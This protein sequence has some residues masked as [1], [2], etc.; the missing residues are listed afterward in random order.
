[1]ITEL[2][3]EIKDPLILSFE[4]NKN[5]NF[6]KSIID[7]INN[8]NI[9][10]ISITNLIP[11]KYLKKIN[12]KFISIDI[13][14]FEF[15]SSVF[16]KISEYNGYIWQ[17]RLN[18]EWPFI[19]DD[20][21][22]TVNEIKQ[23]FKGSIIV[24]YKNNISSIDL[25]NIYKLIKNIISNK[26]IF[27]FF[28]VLDINENDIKYKNLI[29]LL[30]INKSNILNWKILLDNPRIYKRIT[31]NDVICPNNFWMHIDYHWNIKVCKYSNVIIW[32]INKDNLSDLY[33]KKQNYQK[34]LKFKDCFIYNENITYPYQILSKYYDKMMWNKDE[35][36]KKY[37]NI[38][39]ELLINK[40]SKILDLWAWTGNF[41]YFL[42]K[43]WYLNIHWIEKSDNM[44]NIANLKLWKKIVLNWDFSR[45]FK[46]I[47]NVDIITSTFDSLNY[48]TDIQLLKKT[49]IN[50][51]K[52]LKNN[53]YFIF[54]I[55]IDK[56]FKNHFNLT[57]E[58]IQEENKIYFLS[59]YKKPFW[60]IKIDFLNS[61]NNNIFSESHFEI[62]KSKTFILNLLKEVNF[63]I[64]KYE[65]NKWRLLIVCKKR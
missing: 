30:E 26:Y 9:Q 28:P 23:Y 11:V 37:L 53:W 14:Y 61:K 33:D 39:N 6:I 58:Y 15:K 1:M 62:L 41:L 38:L 47:N 5:I 45:N 48:I 59:S 64:I 21:L 25:Q 40:M 44:L 19:V 54:D 55:N 20:I 52:N 17:I 43:N 36:Y 56:K 63:S 2:S 51:Y 16:K 60:K 8:K 22:K 18:I 12:S 31:W 29:K 7:Y 10:T 50:I 65:E 34:T 13:D 32:N 35:L 3:I 42:H 49:F 24:L 27:S 4:Y 57:Q 46:N